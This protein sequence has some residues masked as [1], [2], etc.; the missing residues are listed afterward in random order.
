VPE[1]VAREAGAGLD[2]RA[3]AEKAGPA[4][5]LHSELWEMSSASFFSPSIRVVKKRL[6]RRALCRPLSAFKEFSTE[7]SR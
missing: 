4:V 6:S 2:A 1:E 7:K 3:M 5:L